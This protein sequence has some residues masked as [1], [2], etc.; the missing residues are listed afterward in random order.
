MSPVKEAPAT[1][2]VNTK[3]KHPVSFVLDAKA[4]TELD[5]EL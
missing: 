5:V 3:V 2:D 1:L 4:A